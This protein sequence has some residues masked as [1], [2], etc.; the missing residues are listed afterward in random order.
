MSNRAW[1]A[2]RKILRSSNGYNK[3]V[4]NHFKD[5]EDDG[6]PITFNRKALRDACLIQAN[7]S[8]LMAN[9]RV[10]LFREEVQRAH[11]KPTVIGEFKTNFDEKVTYRCQVVLYFFQD[12]GAVPEGYKPIDARISFRLD[13]THLTITEA[14][15]KILANKIKT[16]LATGTPYSFNK[17]KYLCLYEDDAL[18]YNFQIYTSSETEGENV[19]KKIMSI[20]NHTFN[21]KLFRCST[22]KRNSDNNPGT[23]T[24]L[25][26]SRKKPR[27][28]PTGTV[29]FRYADLVIHDLPNPIVLVDR[30]GTRANPVILAI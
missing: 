22:P 21:E 3:E 27:W 17:G 1:A 25:G 29:K 20:Q 5:I 10:R 30:T 19:I 2:I 15:Y 8:I 26:K 16:E 28:R 13:E 11:L 24:I 9:A 14:K 4:Y 23:V 7:D 18:G 6:T 12:I